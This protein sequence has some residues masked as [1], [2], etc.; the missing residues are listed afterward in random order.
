MLEEPRRSPWST[1]NTEQRMA[2]VRYSP[3][4]QE[5]GHWKLYAL[6][7]QAL[8]RHH[9]RDTVASQ[10]LAEAMLAAVA[11]H[12]TLAQLLLVRM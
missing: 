6:P 4:M 11:V 10:A 9:R 5:R 3:V 7:M 12:G 2:M 1:L 8:G